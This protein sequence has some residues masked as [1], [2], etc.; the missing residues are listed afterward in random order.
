MPIDPTTI[1]FVLI[2]AT[3]IVVGLASFVLSF[4]HGADINLGTLVGLS[5]I[6]ISFS[7]YKTSSSKTKIWGIFVSIIS[8]IL[9]SYLLKTLLQNQLSSNENNAINFL[10]ISFYLLPLVCLAYLIVH[11]FNLLKTRSS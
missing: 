11:F 6:A 9:Y 1:I 5:M 10:I 7:P 8:F 3:L 2:R 4:F